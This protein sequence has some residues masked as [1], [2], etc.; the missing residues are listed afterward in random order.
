MKTSASRPLTQAAR[1][2]LAGR[3]LSV[4]GRVALGVIALG[5]VAC[6]TSEAPGTNGNPLGNGGQSAGGQNAAAAAGGQQG[7]AANNPGG[8]T[9][10]D[11][12]VIPGGGNAGT[13]GAPTTIDPCTDC[14]EFGLD[15]RPAN[16][17][18]L[19]GDAPP[20]AYEWEPVWEGV[21]FGTVLKAV[22]SADGTEMYLAQK[23]GVILAV[24]MDPAAT[25]GREL[26]DLSGLVNSTAESGV[27]SLAVHPD[28]ENNGYVYVT[29]SMMDHSTRVSR[30]QSMDGGLTLDPASEAVIV[31]HSQLRGTHHGG[32]M[33]FGA[34]GYLYVS[35]GDNN[36]GDP[37]HDAATSFLAT[38]PMSRYGKVI[39]VDVNVPGDGF[40]VPADN[41]YANGGGLP[42]V[43]AMGFRNPWRF[44]FDRETDELWLG[45][46]GEEAN[47][48]VGDDGMANP[49]EEIDRVVL[50]GNYGWPSFQ[51]THCYHTCTMEQGLPP[52]Y[53]YSHNGGPAAIVGGY[54]YRGSALPGMYGKYIFGD[55]EQTEIW[56]YDPMTQMTESLGFGGNPVSF[57]QDNDG[58]LYVSREGGTIEK[59]VD[60]NAGAGGFPML[61]SETGCFKPDAPTQVVDAAIP[62]TVSVP[63]WSDGADKARFVALPDGET[64]GVAADGDITLP[65]G[66]VTIKNFSWQGQL[67]ETRFFVRHNDGSYYGYSYE[68][69][70]AQTEATL[71]SGQ[72][73][74]RSLPGLEWSYPSTA[75]CFTC[76]SDAAGRSLGLEVR[77][78]NSVGTYGA[79]R[80]NQLDTLVHIGV[81]SAP[82]TPLEAY[83]PLSIAATPVEVRAKSYL[84]VNCSNCHRPGGP[85]RGTMDAR[86]DTPLA[87]MGVCNQAPEHGN[88]EVAGSTL[89]T[90]GNHMSSV[91][92]LRMSQRDAD[93]MPPIASKLPDEPAAAV[94]AEWIDSLA[95]CP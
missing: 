72:G 54:V 41:P 22:P 60:S 84:A 70:D 18:C 4:Q 20:T 48:N 61:L 69:N 40:N 21:T 46:P 65:V 38:D 33:A 24:P 8:G 78:L 31:E 90:P 51:G 86:F 19:A 73:K 76:H 36:S 2:A 89:L 77:Q 37:P 66:A 80:A 82:A 63:L 17:T 7:A 71:V 55:Y 93:F 45:D 91:M 27:L 30:F 1:R 3:S 5:I 26:L 39:R 56:A 29:Y 94:L 81:L 42:E 28:F 88:L 44:S 49:W 13:G 35:F 62:F 11:G 10:G 83:V 16:P 58:E 87:E 34:D 12:Q 52:E 92:W 6:G 15:A 32:D 43:Y 53:E 64:M 68:W 67:F 50:G 23:E 9:A 75:Q 14:V 47:G 95:T 59:L 57:A 74:A 85:G 79:L 25:Q